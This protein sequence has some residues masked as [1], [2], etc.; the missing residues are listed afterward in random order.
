MNKSLL[1][2]MLG[3]LNKPKFIIGLILSFVGTIMSLFL[4]QFIGNLLNEEFLKTLLSNNTTLMITIGLFA[5][6][7]TVQALSSYLI[8]ECG[9]DSLK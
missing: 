7:Y 5:S 4:P 8:G 1:Y 9:S 3:F 2:L 6:I